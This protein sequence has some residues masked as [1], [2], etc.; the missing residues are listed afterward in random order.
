MVFR[1][2]VARIAQLGIHSF[3]RPW[4]QVKLD[5][6]VSLSQTTE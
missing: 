4:F 6:A 1:I 3:A 2:N 5:C